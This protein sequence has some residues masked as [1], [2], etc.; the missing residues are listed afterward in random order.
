ME[1]EACFP[2]EVGA[3]AKDYI[4]RMVEKGY[5]NIALICRSA[6]AASQIEPKIGLEYSV[7]SKINFRVLPLY[8]AKGLEYD[9][10]IL[11][12]IPEELMYTACTRAM[13]E[14][15]VIRKGETD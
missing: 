12:D 7:L 6:A 4:L 11:W 1:A 3:A 15:F 5:E 9:C 2:E 13:H 10:A 14:L 8:L